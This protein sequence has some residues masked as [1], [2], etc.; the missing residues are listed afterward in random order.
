MSRAR[1]HVHLGPQIGALGKLSDGRCAQVNGVALS[2]ANAHKVQAA[3]NAAVLR[4]ARLQPRGG[5][6]ESFAAPA[7]GRALSPA[8]TI[9]FRKRRTVPEGRSRH[10]RR[11]SASRP[12]AICDT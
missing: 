3:I 2:P 6:R 10:E 1:W 7:P 12:H 4:P 9:T 5:E 11:F 8:V